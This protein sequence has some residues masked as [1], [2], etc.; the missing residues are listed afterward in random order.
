M[1]HIIE[2]YDEENDGRLSRNLHGFLRRRRR[3]LRSNE[4]LTHFIYLQ[5]ITGYRRCR[6]KT[7]SRLTSLT[8]I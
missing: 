1:P 7:F 4:E 3:N 2:S 5:W 6:K 8:F